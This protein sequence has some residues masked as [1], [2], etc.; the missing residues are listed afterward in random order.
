MSRTLHLKVYVGVETDLN[1]L[2]SDIKDS[3]GVYLSGEGICY[4]INYN[5][6][7]ASG[8]NVLAACMNHAETGK[9]Y[10]DYN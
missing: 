3:K 7:Q 6:D 5:G 10:A 9:F 4:V 8:L 1:A 2:W